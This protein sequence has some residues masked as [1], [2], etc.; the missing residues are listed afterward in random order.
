MEF[1]LSLVLIGVGFIISSFLTYCEKEWVYML[2]GVT[3]F[4][5]GVIFDKILIYTLIGIGAGMLL[6]KICAEF[7]YVNWIV[8][9]VFVATII[10]LLLR[11]VILFVIL[12]FIIVAVVIHVISN[13]KAN[14]AMREKIKRSGSI[15]NYIVSFLKSNKINDNYFENS[16]WCCGFFYPEISQIIDEYKRN[17]LKNVKDSSKY[18]EFLFEGSKIRKVMVAEIY[19]NSPVDSVPGYEILDKNGFTIEV[20]TVYAYIKMN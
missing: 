2:F 16:R 4:F 6:S 1:I 12:G 14:D 5:V 20:N 17:L 15:S 19:E 7:E 9:A 18:S 13:K 10:G 3:G 11:H 8:I